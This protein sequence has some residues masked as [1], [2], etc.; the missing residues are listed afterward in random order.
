MQINAFVD[1][2]L[3]GE[4][5]TRRSRTGILIFLNMS[6]TVWYFKRQN[7]A[8]A[9]TYG[10]EFVTMR[11]LVEMLIVLR[12]KLRLFGLPI[13]GPCND[14]CDND[15]VDRT[16]MRAENTLK[17]KHLSISFHK[18]REAVTC[19]IM[20][21]F[22]ERYGSNLSDLYTKLLAS[23]DRTHIMSSICGK[24]PHT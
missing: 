7:T 16:A 11:I 4:V 15:A 2:Y 5:T 6:P 3:A 20:L 12:Y 24:L 19:G 17:K 1:A 23:I 13:D 8:E 14:F 22:F 21:V 18:S 10:S 9:S